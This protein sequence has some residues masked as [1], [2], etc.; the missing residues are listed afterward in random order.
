MRLILFLVCALSLSG[1]PPCLAAEGRLR[2]LRGEQLSGVIRWESNGVVV[3]HSDSGFIRFVALHDLRRILIH[4]ASP[5]SWAPP[6]PP[7]EIELV[8][9]LPFPW[10]AGTIGRP[11]G[12]AESTWREGIFRV[13]TQGASLGQTVESGRMIFER[14][15]GNREIQVRLS[16]QSVY[17]DDT[18]AGLMFRGGLG[19]SDPS[20]FLGSAAGSREDV[21]E[22]KP[23]ASAERWRCQFPALGGHRW[24]KLKREGDS[25]SAYRSRDGLRWM[26]LCRTNVALP[27][28]TLMGVAAA[29][30]SGYRVHRAWFDQISHAQRMESPMGVRVELQA[31]GVLECPGLEWDSGLLRFLGVESRPKVRL[32]QVARLVFQSIPSRS[33]RRLQDGQRGILLTSGEFLEGEPRSLV[34]GW[35]TLDSVLFGRRRFDA[36]NEAVAVV[37]GPSRSAE[38]RYEVTLTDG[39]VFRARDLGLEGYRLRL[40][41]TTLGFCTVPVSDLAVLERVYD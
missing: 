12:P 20:V 24:Y 14:I 11:S 1:P 36:L 39:S 6:V 37:F 13:E 26:L 29:G 40:D 10:E 17:P 31:G 7:L 30:P 23:E 22:W 2:T 32:D 33:Q 41:E 8:D 28:D 27:R 9:G 25:F 4:S 18:R 38:A 34:E 21:F 3:V 16:R 5:P 35:I 15:R 19:E